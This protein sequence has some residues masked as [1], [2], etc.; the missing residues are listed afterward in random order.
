YILPLL[1]NKIDDYKQAEE[2]LQLI[3]KIITKNEY[4]RL[5]KQKLTMIILHLLLTYLNNEENEFYDKWLPEPILPAYTWSILRN[6]FDYIKQIM[7][8]KTFSELLIKSAV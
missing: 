1:A 5:M 4:N 6:T 3:E 8:T 7:N 2:H